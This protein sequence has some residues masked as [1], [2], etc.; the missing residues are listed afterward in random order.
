[1]HNS[2]PEYVSTA[3][4][5][6]VMAMPFHVKPFEKKV[7]EEVIF[8]LKYHQNPQVLKRWIIEKREKNIEK[9]EKEKERKRNKRKKKEKLHESLQIKGKLIF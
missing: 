4:I 8:L 6:I 5:S 3:S 7:F 2:I 9:R 1:V